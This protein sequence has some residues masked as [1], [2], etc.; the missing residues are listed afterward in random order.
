M[1]AESLLDPE[2]LGTLFVVDSR[3]PAHYDKAIECA[4]IGELLIIIQS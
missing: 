2:L 3:R 4:K 1:K